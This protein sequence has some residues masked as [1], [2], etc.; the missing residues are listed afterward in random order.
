[1]ESLGAYEART[2]LTQL[3]EYVVK[4]AKTMTTK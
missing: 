4:G 3:L 2:N 1:M